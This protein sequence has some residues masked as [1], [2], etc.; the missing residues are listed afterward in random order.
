MS[1]SK[2]S[3]L[4]RPSLFILA[5]VNIG[6]ALEWYE[7]GLF[8]SWPL[9]IQGSSNLFDQ[10]LADSLNLTGI[11]LMVGFALA[12]GGARALGGWFFGKMGDKEGRRRFP[13]QFYWQHYLL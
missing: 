7:I 9:I 5:A 13:Y 3:N 6:G 8:I 10:T 12:S 11:L 2:I 1:I 4:V